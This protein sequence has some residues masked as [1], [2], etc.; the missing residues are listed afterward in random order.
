M[1]SESALSIKSK[2]RFLDKKKEKTTLHNCNVCRNDYFDNEMPLNRKEMEARR[3]N[4]GKAFTVQGTLFLLRLCSWYYFISFLGSSWTN[5]HTGYTRENG[6]VA[7]YYGHYP[8]DWKKKEDAILQILI[9]MGKAIVRRSVAM[10]VKQYKRVE[11]GPS[12]SLSLKKTLYTHKP[13]SVFLDV[14]N[15]SISPLSFT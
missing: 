9:I 8:E 7:C 10:V 5:S 3:E 11:T 14:S 15:T 12:L 13:S 4:R 2:A 1:E 6:R